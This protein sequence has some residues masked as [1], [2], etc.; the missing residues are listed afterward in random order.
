L[1]TWRQSSLIALLVK[2]APV[3]AGVD[4][5]VKGE[6]LLASPSTGVDLEIGLRGDK[7]LGEETAVGAETNTILLEVRSLELDATTLVHAEHGKEGA[8]DATL[9][10]DRVLLLG[11]GGAERRVE[12]TGEGAL[13]HAV[14]LLVVELVAARLGLAA[15][16]RSRRSVGLLVVSVGADNDYLEAVLVLAVVGSRRLGNILTPESALEA[17][18]RVGLC[19]RALARVPL[20]ITLNEEVETSAG[21]GALALGSAGGSVVAGKLVVSKVTTARN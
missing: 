8:D 19:A 13:T 4:I 9:A 16:R 18:N 7:L 10:V 14:W 3:E 21:G 5:N 17:G 11:I 12:R 6:G 15:R 1:G 20:G 2:A